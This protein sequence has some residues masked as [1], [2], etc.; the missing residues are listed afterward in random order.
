MYS[1]VFV[2]CTRYNYCTEGSCSQLTYLERNNST[3]L[4]DLR[5]GGRV[6]TETEMWGIN[7]LDEAQAALFKDPIRTAL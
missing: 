5:E 2:D 1:I 6:K 4:T 7:H 3:E